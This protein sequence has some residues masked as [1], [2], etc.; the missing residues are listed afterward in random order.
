[1]GL[2][3]HGIWA[4]LR[5][6]MRASQDLRKI[7][8]RI[9][10]RPY[11]SIRQNRWVSLGF[12]GY[13]LQIYCWDICNMAFGMGSGCQSPRP[14]IYIKSRPRPKFRAVVSSAGF[15][16]L[17]AP[18]ILSNSDSVT[19]GRRARDRKPDGRFLAKNEAPDPPRPIV[20]SVSP[21]TSPA[22]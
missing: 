9:Y 11:C 19:C 5:K 12:R 20:A 6:P 18:H 10:D 13:R 2:R 8:F 22:I 4:R 3:R 7:E 1:M 16:Q 17:P 14:D 21:P 15:P